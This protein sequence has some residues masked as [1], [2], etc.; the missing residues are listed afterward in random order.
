MNEKIICTSE[1]VDCIH[2][3]INEIDKAHIKIYCE[4]KE[5]EYWYGQYIP[6]DEWR[7]KR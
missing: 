6:C 5:K 4:K 2:C 1:C 3:E 7:N